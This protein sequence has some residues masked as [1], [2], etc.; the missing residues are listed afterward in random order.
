MILSDI[1]LPLKLWVDNRVDNKF[2]KMKVKITF[3]IFHSATATVVAK[4]KLVK[5]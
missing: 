3:L 4:A 2:D 5:Y 1:T